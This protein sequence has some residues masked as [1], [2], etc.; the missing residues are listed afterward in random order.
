MNR[1]I[2]CLFCDKRFPHLIDAAIHMMAEHKLAKDED[3]SRDQR[4]HYDADSFRCP[5]SRVG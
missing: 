1:D 5:S 3:N 2:P 4:F